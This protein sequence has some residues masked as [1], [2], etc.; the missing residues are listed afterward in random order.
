VPGYQS[1]TIYLHSE[2]A[3]VVV[4]INTTINPP[5]ALIPLVN[6]LAQAITTIITPKHVYVPWLPRATEIG[7]RRLVRTVPFALL[8]GLA[9]PVTAVAPSHSC[10]VCRNGSVPVCG[11]SSHT[12]APERCWFAIWDGHAWRPEPL[13]AL[14]VPRL[15]MTQMTHRPMILLRGPLSALR[16][17]SF[18]VH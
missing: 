13:R 7:H 5:D 11:V 18:H 6:R 10:S 4:L 9:G 17:T 16:A 2:R 3:T 15:Q 8:L 14:V 1:L 12:R